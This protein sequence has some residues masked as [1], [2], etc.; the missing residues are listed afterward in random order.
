MREPN[1]RLVNAH[2]R[3][4]LARLWGGS[5][6]SSSDDQRFAQRGRA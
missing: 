2:H 6:V 5:T 3:H 1:A 4:P